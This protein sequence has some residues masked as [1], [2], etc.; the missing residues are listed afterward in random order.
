MRLGIDFL[1]L[2][3]SPGGEQNTVFVE[4]FSHFYNPDASCCL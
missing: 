4:I 2:S 1:F 3:F